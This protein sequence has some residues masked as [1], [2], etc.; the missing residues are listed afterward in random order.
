MPKT[1]QFQ[2]IQVPNPGF[3]A[4]S[5]SGG[6]GPADDD[7]SLKVLARAYELGCTFWDTA[8][9]YGMGHNEEL[10]GRFLKATPGAREKLFIGS[11]CGWDIDFEK[12]TN[13]GVIN[14]A[15]HIHKTIDSSI[16][17]LGTTPDLY[18]LHRRDPRT[19][20]EETIGA[21]AEIKK[22]GK[23][24]YI[25]ISECSAETLRAACKIAHIDALQIEYS[26]WYTDHE[27]NDLIAAARD[28]GVTIIAYS[29]LGKGMLTGK[30]KDASQFAG[31]IR[32][33][34]PRFS[35]ENLPKNLRLVEEFEKLAKAKGCTPG[36]LS[37]AWVAAQGAIPIPG[38]KS[39]SRLEENFGA[40]KVDLSEAE[41][42]AIR[43]II[44][45]AEPVGNR[46]SDA[47][48][49]MVGK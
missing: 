26:P 11:K 24:K 19:P 44:V 46:Y 6:Y 12:K 18:Y 31:D 45:S 35:A 15:E 29:P 5:L 41:L 42:K 13:G 4:M 20:L 23:C 22:A 40:G 27:R 14:T 36:Q 25:G 47:H 28:N 30:Y 48:M 38:T 39:V 32:G 3:G 43:E 21:L 7:E 34:A 49:A 37:I 8:A 17:R 2:D 16:K 1:L 9:V 10:I 33:S